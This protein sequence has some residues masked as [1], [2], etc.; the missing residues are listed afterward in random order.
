[1]TAT[2][3]AAKSLASM[4]GQ[5]SRH[6]LRHPPPPPPAVRSGWLCSGRDAGPGA[7]RT[8]VYRRR[9]QAQVDVGLLRLPALGCRHERPAGG[10]RRASAVRE[11]ASRPP[12]V[13]GRMDRYGGARQRQHSTELGPS[14]S[15][16]AAHA[17]WTSW[18]TA[19]RSGTSR[20]TAKWTGAAVGPAYRARSGRL[21]LTGDDA[22]EG[23]ADR[24]RLSACAGPSQGS[25][26]PPPRRSR[27]QPR[28]SSSRSWCSWLGSG[29]AAAAHV[30]SPRK[31]SLR[32][33]AIRDSCSTTPTR[34]QAEPVGAS[35]AS[36]QVEMRRRHGE[37]CLS[38]LPTRPCS[39]SSLP[40]CQVSGGALRIVGAR[41]RLRCLERDSFVKRF[42]GQEAGR[43][44]TRRGI[45]NEQQRQRR[46]G[47][48]VRG[49]RAGQRIEGAV[50]AH[51]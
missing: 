22:G 26:R 16:T 25:R 23:R 12:G 34:N 29:Q 47:H 19:T 46:H 35:S 3:P 45:S 33:K 36:T 11:V 40:S 18:A 43:L 27:W 49:A 13:V 24:T 48:S 4:A 7:T 51:D 8:T 30:A 6:R 39:T 38:P 1:M 21:N 32:W 31:P 17:S 10:R 14:R 41:G 44:C 2:T 37:R 20:R 9:H 15:R 42:D 28:S 50:A 5:L